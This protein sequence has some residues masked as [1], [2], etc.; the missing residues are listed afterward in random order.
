[1]TAAVNLFIC[2]GQL[3]AVGIGN[4]RFAIMTPASY[5]VLFAAQWA[6][7]VFVL[8]CIPL[9]PE[10]PW[11]LVRKQQLDDARKSLVRL[12]RKN[13]DIDQLLGD[14][15]L[16][17]AAEMN[18]AEGGKGVSY[19]DCFRGIN[20]RRTRIVCGMFV[21]QQFTGIA[22]YAQALY[23]L[24]I[25][26]LDIK[27]TFQLALAGFGA[28]LVGNVASWFIMD[29]VGRRTL[30]LVGIVINGLLLMAVGIAGSV[31]ASS[32]ALFF[33]GFAMN[34]AQLFYA[35]TVGAVTWTVSAETSSTRMRAKT[36]GLATVT[37]A[38]V[39]WIMN[40]VTPYLIN[41]DEAN[42]GGK[43]GFL[44]LG[45]CVL[46]FGW[47]W[48]DVPEFKGRDFVEIDYLFETRTPA[49]QFKRAQVPAASQM[50][51]KLEC[52]ATARD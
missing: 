27:L 1:M 52:D 50:A 21:I 26:G 45:L 13:V 34:F 11:Y 23:F 14:V 44:W 16:A 20:A 4:T 5:R 8:A 47:V 22:F 17:A 41:S 28:G 12:H 2:A 25:T 36:Q 38:V 9:M 33:I 37:N 29:Y 40:F 15:S 31:P 39:S 42:L 7:P 19:A 10:S 24:G 43:A 49:R 48:M 18:L 35:P 6:F 46:G 3:M 51:D 32:G 30:L